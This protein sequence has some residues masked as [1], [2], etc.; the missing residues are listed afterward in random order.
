[1]FS[2]TLCP[3]LDNIAL[4]QWNFGKLSTKV[5]SDPAINNGVIR[6]HWWVHR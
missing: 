5:V 1:M 6:V 3:R 4:S 2:L